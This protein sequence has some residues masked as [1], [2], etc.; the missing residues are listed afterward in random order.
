MPVS[1]PLA[2]CRKLILTAFVD[3]KHMSIKR[4]TLLAGTAIACMIP[5]QVAAAPGEM[6]VETR[7]ADPDPGFVPPPAERKTAATP[8]KAKDPTLDEAFEGLGRAIGQAAQVMHQKAIDRAAQ[9][10]DTG[11]PPKD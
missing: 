11:E 10:R 7:L 4:R 5:G 9:A 3:F 8:R 1:A 6:L 2:K